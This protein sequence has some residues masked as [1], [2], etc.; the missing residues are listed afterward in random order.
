[1]EGAGEIINLIRS[2]LRR[3]SEGLA[4]ASFDPYVFPYTYPSHYLLMPAHGAS[5]AVSDKDD[6]FLPDPAYAQ[7]AKFSKSSSQ[8]FFRLPTQD[9]GE[10]KAGTEHQSTF[11]ESTCSELT[12]F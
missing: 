11:V 4:T 1:M 9:S 8:A 6:R 2:L 3:P 12:G 10:R 7:A 5:K